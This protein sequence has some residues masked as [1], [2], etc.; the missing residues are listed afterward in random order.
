MICLCLE[1]GT[2]FDQLTLTCNYAWAAVPCGSANQFYY[3]NSNLY[4]PD[5]QFI[6]D[7]DVQRGRS[8]NSGQYR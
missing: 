4:Q 1:T 2:I 8:L 3:V 6:S 5:A 7:A